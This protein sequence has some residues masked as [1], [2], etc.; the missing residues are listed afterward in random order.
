METDSGAP[1]YLRDDGRPKPLRYDDQSGSLTLTPS[2]LLFTG[3]R[4]HR[5]LELSARRGASPD[6]FGNWYW[7]GNDRQRIFWLPRG[8]RRP[9][10]FWS[11]ASEKGCE[12]RGQFTPV[13]EERPLIAELA[14]L[15]VTA[16][17]YLLVG[18]VT[19]G[20]L[21]LFDLHAGGEPMLLLFPSRINFEPFDM[22][23]TPEG[24]VWI[25]DRK[26]RAYWGLDRHF[27]VA[28]EEAQLSEVVPAAELV[29]HPDGEPATI[30][31]RRQFPEGFQIDATDPVSIEALPDGSVL[32]LDRT[33]PAPPLQTGQTVS[34]VLRYRFAQLVAAPL[35][36][37]DEVEVIP[38]GEGKTLRRLNIIAYD[39][40]YTGDTL[41]VVESEGNQALAF[42]LK[43][44]AW[45]ARLKV[46]TDF[47]PMHY[48]GSR[49]LVAWEQMIFYDVVGGDMTR[50]EVVN[51]VQ[52]HSVEQPRFERTAT[53]LTPV[54]DGKE[55]DCT[56]HR[57]FLDACIPVESSVEV[58]TRAHNEQELLESVPFTREPPPYLRGAGAELPFYD[59]FPDREPLPERTGTWEL[60]FQQ[61][62]GRYLEIRLVISGNERVSPHLHALRAY[63]P[64]FS[65]PQHYL[66]NVYL[67][68]E[69]SAS[70]LER[71]LTNPEGFYTEIEGKINDVSM[72]FDS[73]SAPPEVLDWL[74]EWVGIALDPLWSRIQQQRG[75]SENRSGRASDRR[76]LF[77]RFTRKLYDRRG[78]PTGLLFA[79]HLLLD[80]CLELTL[81]RL[82][83]IAVR[84]DAH[85]ALRDQ[86]ERLK[87]S[88]PTAAWSE[89]QFEDLLY[90]YVLAPARPT[91]VRLVERY[92]ARGGRAGVAGDPTAPESDASVSNRQN[93]AHQFSVL[94]PEG[95]TA[96]EEMMV[97][98]IA[99]LEKPAHTSF[100]VRHYWDFFRVG[101]TRLGIDTVL[102]EESRFK[103]M[104]VGRSYL[105]EGYLHPSHPMD[106]AERVVSDRDRAGYLPPL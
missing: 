72:L 95:I 97:K 31:P 48:F 100:D 93:Y 91:S 49:A 55:R 77:I 68:D 1:V 59:A 67:E 105:A 96:E 102:G 42:E 56:W 65:Y 43:L 103:K 11:Q 30:H 66:P 50:D 26:H 99:N 98:R 57:L 27:C 61:A 12:P 90:E 47:L 85:R 4:E 81:Q 83:T 39:F 75:A 73:R 62:R 14:G 22:A 45:P 63:F 46:K 40:A 25:L 3:T 78:T 2:L 33:S 76:R 104:V 52:L 92:R 82:K 51:W 101:E 37:M 87:F 29:F 24:G 53:L 10:L 71:L 86:L 5:P 88:L 44:P 28:T 9:K 80:P 19:Q 7:I 74:A 84:Q 36:L 8:A 15:V 79:L 94:I 64:R 41:Y 58:W 106:I 35:P 60:L 70:F 89:E 38:E 54:L 20:G 69:E 34:R 23:A 21:F 13:T 17:H 32:I 18:N 6:A 16:H